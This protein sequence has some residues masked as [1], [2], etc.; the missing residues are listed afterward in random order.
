MSL[1]E[2]IVL[3]SIVAKFLLPLKYA[4]WHLNAA[5]LPLPKNKRYFSHN[6][7]PGNHDSAAIFLCMQYPVC[8]VLPFSFVYLKNNMAKNKS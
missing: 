8:V 5:K 6:S 4:I 3:L 2:F 1:K 7:Q